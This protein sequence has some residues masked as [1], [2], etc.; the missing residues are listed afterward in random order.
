MPRLFGHGPER[1]TFEH[2]A[3]K[4]RGT[5]SVSIIAI[6][7]TAYYIFNVTPLLILI[8]QF[9]LPMKFIMSNLWLFAPL[10]GR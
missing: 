5:S 7:L 6:T 3:H 8:F 9:G 1:G 10:L 4:V 2:L